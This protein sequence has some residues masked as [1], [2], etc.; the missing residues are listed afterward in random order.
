MSIK[1]ALVIYQAVMRGML[2]K[3]KGRV[4]L[5]LK[6]QIGD[7]EMSL[8]FNSTAALAEHHM[9]AHNHLL[10][11]FRGSSAFFKALLSPHKRSTDIHA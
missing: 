5:A 6:S 7:G 4:V 3:T 11:Q 10:L 9:V 8:V 2:L 1:D